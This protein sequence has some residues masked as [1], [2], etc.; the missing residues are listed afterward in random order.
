MKKTMKKIEFRLINYDSNRSFDSCCD[1]IHNDDSEEICELRKCIHAI[2]Y[3]YDCY[4]KRGDEGCK[5]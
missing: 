2:R 5:N 1:C 3:L 4:E